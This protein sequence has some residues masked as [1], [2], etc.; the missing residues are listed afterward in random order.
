M[1]ILHDA[2]YVFL[3]CILLVLNVEP[4]VLERRIVTCTTVFLSSRLLALILAQTYV[5]CFSCLHR[6]I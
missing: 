3:F 4:C 5:Y 6:E 1:D 2:F